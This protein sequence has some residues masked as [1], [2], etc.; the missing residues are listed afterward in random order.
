MPAECDICK[1]NLNLLQWKYKRRNI[2]IQLWSFLFI[3]RK[4]VSRAPNAIKQCLLHHRNDN[5]HDWKHNINVVQSSTGIAGD[6][7]PITKRGSVQI[8]LKKSAYDLDD[9][10][11]WR[12]RHLM[13]GF[14]DWGKQEVYPRHSPAA[15]LKLSQ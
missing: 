12:S 2:H 1:G 3:L 14:Q 4:H 5:T 13:T 9:L 11:C 6:Q 10:V 7:Q 8:E 15:S